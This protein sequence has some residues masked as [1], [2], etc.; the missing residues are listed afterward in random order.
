VSRAL[1]LEHALRLLPPAFELA[2]VQA[3]VDAD[4]FAVAA[5]TYEE[6]SL[7]ALEAVAAGT[8][9]VLTKQCEIPGLHAGGGIV[10]ECDP[11]AFA[12]GLSTVLADPHR[13]ERARFAR[14]RILAAETA[15]QRAKSYAELFSSIVAE[16]SSTTHDLEKIFRVRN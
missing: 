1:G 6:T 16:R 15:G 7:A 2:R 5:T 11:E 13:A 9:C 12:A 10:T 3:Y 8:P 4:I 14:E